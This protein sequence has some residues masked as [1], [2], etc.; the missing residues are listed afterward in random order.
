[1]GKTNFHRIHVFL[2]RGYCSAIESVYT[3][4][5]GAA[6]LR[7]IPTKFSPHPSSILRRP[8]ILRGAG[9]HDKSNKDFVA[10]GG[11]NG[12]ILTGNEN[13]FISRGDPQSRETAEGKND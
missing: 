11:L 5:T 2:T 8:R 7:M 13:I 9:G 10:G 1:M 12:G 6:S 4:N 3:Y